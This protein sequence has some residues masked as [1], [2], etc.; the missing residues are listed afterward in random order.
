MVVRVRG[1]AWRRAVFAGTSLVAMGHAL[2]AQE[3]P[4]RP[5]LPSA[6]DRVSIVPASTEG[7][8][9]RG[10]ISTSRRRVSIAPGPLEPALRALTEQTGLKLAYETT[11][12]AGLTA[13]GIAGEFRPLDALAKLLDGT[14]LTF[15]SAGSSTITLV[16]PRYVQLDAADS[17]TQVTL[18]EL[19]VTGTG[20]GQPPPTGTVG[21]PPPV[22][23]GGQVATG[24]RL[25]LL[26][27]RSVFDTPFTQNNYTEQLIRDQGARTVLDVLAND[28]SVRAVQP[29]F[30]I[31]DNIYIRGF[32]VN[33]RDF[34]FDGLYGIVDPRKAAIE[35]VSRIEVLHGPA[36]FLFGF[37]PAGNIG[38][39]VN[40]VPKRA[41]DEPITRV[42][43]DYLS[44]GNGGGQVDVGRRFGDGN[45]LGVRVNAFY[46][47][48]QTPID[49]QSI[50]NGGFT[51]GLDYRG[52]AFRFSVDFGYHHLGYIAPTLGIT[53]LPGFRIPRAPD[54]TRNLQQRWEFTDVDHGFGTARAEYDVA[55]GWTAF[56]AVG[57]SSQS[58]TF[59]NSRLTIAN[60]RGDLRGATLPFVD[61]ED[62]FTAEVG[63]RGGLDTGAIHHAV[64]LVGTEYINN[65]PFAFTSTYPFTSNLYAPTAVPPPS[66]LGLFPRLIAPQ[67]QELTSLAGADTITLI[68]D[69]L[70]IIA[71]ARA[72]WIGVKSYDNSTGSLSSSYDASAITPL[73]A[74]VLKP[75]RWLS[76]Y[77][78][79]AEG[80]GFGPQA[81]SNAAN[82]NA[83][84]PPVVT[85]QL[86]TGAKLDLGTVGL[87]FA[88][89][90]ITQPSGFLNPTTNIFGVNGEQRN[91]G[92]EFNVFGEPLPGLRLLGGVTLLDGVLTK[93]AGGT[94]NGKVAPGVPDAQ[95]NL[96]A[97]IDLPRWL[98]PGLTL[99]ARVI[100]TSSQYYDQANTQK[101]PDWTRLDLGLRYRFVVNETPL[102]ARFNVENVAGLN[103]W[104]STGQGNLSLGQPRTFRLSLT[105][106]L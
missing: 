100:H 86:E 69:T 59:L 46:H 66:R 85:R 34:A 4:A 28:P 43:A 57:G 23:A 50:Q 35:G 29:P 49:F 31:Q 62:Q 40:L 14:G 8:P 61:R 91:R 5:A 48:G 45:A 87:T 17:A 78:S 60:A 53:V 84:L 94:L 72:Q 58:E 56:A 11:L 44:R 1:A 10:E 26:G 93:T 13:P 36:A 70:D 25:G 92:F 7:L 19:S 75:V 65:N 27:N 101:I 47:D 96:G 12:T 18:E 37:P 6:G 81:P 68:P 103:Y 99:A 71:G 105:A 98:I 16:N 67:R 51:V 90:E 41:T 77:A 97:E 83:F 76:L 63:V 54:L 80:L 30:G 33:A 42:S 74:A 55:P 39:V 73:G 82:A 2:A 52:D 21:Q 3:R 102:I 20:V 64:S 106:D 15:S 89:F 104:A 79:Y 9:P 38:G 32:L 24:G 88:F 95:L 22:Y